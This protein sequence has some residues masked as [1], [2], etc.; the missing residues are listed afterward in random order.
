MDV[1]CERCRTE[2]E[3][4]DERITEA[5]VTVKCTACGHVFRVKK[6]A[7]P[8]PI[9]ST[10]EWKVRQRNG[11]VFSFK[12]LATLQKWIVER[13]VRRDDEISLKGESWKR[14]GDVA[15]LAS[16]FQ[17]VDE[18]QRATQSTIQ[19]ASSA[20]AASNLGTPPTSTPSARY[21]APVVVF[22]DGSRPSENRSSMEERAP[23]PAA[24]ARSARFEF[25]HALP[26]VPGA[27]EPAFARTH[28]WKTLFGDHRAIAAAAGVR[29][30]P[31]RR[32]PLIIVGLIGVAAG[33][34]LLLWLP[35]QERNAAN[36]AAEGQIVQQV[37][38]AGAMTGA[39][40]AG[41]EQAGTAKPPPP[42]ES[43]SAPRSPELHSPEAASPEPHSTQAA[44]PE[45]SQSAG[46][47]QRQTPSPP[48]QAASSHRA[49]VPAESLVQGRAP[50]ESA[51]ADASTLDEAKAPTAASAATAPSDADA[52]TR[53]VASAE[54]RT[55]D[56][57]QGRGDRLRE[58][59]QP[60]AALEAYR[61]A[62][63]LEPSRAEP[64]AGRGLALLDMGQQLQAQI[65]FR[66]ALKLNPRYSVALMGLAEAYRAEG[67]T[68]EAIQY[69]EKYLEVMPDGP[70]ALV[71]QEAIKNLREPSRE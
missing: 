17:I 27:G 49:A 55:F 71:A 22:P 51:G 58:R 38:P 70:E 56:F 63:E 26:P 16:F 61:K 52:R 41:P 7:R 60:Q 50:S 8:A 6:A 10:K 19:A 25:S 69:Y 44:G 3:F 1:R 45:R 13:S 40:A 65:W 62:A 37:P 68:S 4:D 11:N 43:V 47:E 20:S 12:E 34:Y 33:G 29:A 18:A 28:P 42:T 48:E 21:P 67:K 31:P 57:Y 14:L 24:S 66:Q 9:E 59:E 54:P 32:L 53:K 2:Y 46:A 39:P 5:G 36:K 23:A 30:R 35:A 64:L 15:E